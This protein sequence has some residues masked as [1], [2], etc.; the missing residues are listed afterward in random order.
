[1]LTIDGESLTVEEV[2]RVAR[3]GE[4]VKLSRVASR[5]IGASRAALV[6]IVEP[7]FEYVA[8]ADHSHPRG[9]KLR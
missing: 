6:R 5:R 2:V 4:P 8:R 3:A 9:R 1:M 7:E